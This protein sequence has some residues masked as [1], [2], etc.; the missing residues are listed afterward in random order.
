MEKESGEIFRKL[1]KDLTTYME[2]KLGLLKLDT[3]ERIGKVV[4]VLSYGIILLFL[5]FFAILFIFLTLGFWLGYLFQSTACGFGIVALLY[6]L[7]FFLI[8]KNKKGICD[9]V[10]DLVLAAL[11]SNDDNSNPV[12]DE[13]A[14]TDTPRE[15]ES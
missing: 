13:S 11:T 6:L 2:L 10:Q 9:K 12:T 1:K 7:I 14:T 4:A 8:V 3:Y 15:T 5:A